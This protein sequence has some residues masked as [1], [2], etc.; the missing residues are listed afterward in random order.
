VETR[1]LKETVRGGDIRMG[2]D[3]ILKARTYLIISGDDRKERGGVM[4][5]LHMHINNAP[6]L[7]GNVTTHGSDKKLTPVTKLRNRGHTGYPQYEALI[8][9]PEKN[10]PYN[11]QWPK[12]EAWQWF[13]KKENTHVK[14]PVLAPGETVD[15]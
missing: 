4:I 11:H 12:G 9:E 15:V 5:E 6:I 7:N 2:M 14:L 10:A 13:V 8:H 1:K 3:L